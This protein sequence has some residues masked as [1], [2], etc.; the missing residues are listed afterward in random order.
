MCVG[1]AFLVR[2]AFAARFVDW[3]LR[4]IAKIAIAVAL[5]SSVISP[6]GFEGHASLTLLARCAVGAC[7]YGVTAWLLNVVGVRKPL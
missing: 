5:L 4:D 7:V 2:S 1:L 3:P 6:L